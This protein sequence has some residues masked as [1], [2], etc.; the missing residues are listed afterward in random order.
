MP[1]N[2]AA[3]SW[4]IRP[5]VYQSIAAASRISWPSSRGER[6]KSAK[7]SMGTSMVIAAMTSSF[8]RFASSGRLHARTGSEYIPWPRSR[9][10]G[11]L[12]R[13]KWT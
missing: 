12:P 10:Q 11:S 8:P 7:A 4:E 9:R 1:A 3:F 2:W 6:F 5:W 13:V